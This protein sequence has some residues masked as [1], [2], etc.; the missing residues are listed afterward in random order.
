VPGDVPRRVTRLHPAVAAYQEANCQRAVEQTVTELG[1]IDL[2]VNN[3]GT[4]QPVTT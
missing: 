2:L 1:G 4:Q 3:A